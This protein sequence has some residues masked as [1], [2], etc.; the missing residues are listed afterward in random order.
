MAEVP[1][2]K[3][4]DEAHG[5]SDAHHDGH[6]VRGMGLVLGVGA[7]GDRR[8]QDFGKGVLTGRGAADGPEDAHPACDSERGLSTGRCL[9]LLRHRDGTS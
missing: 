1:V 3:A 7:D 4:V 8:Q 5:A 9:V 6:H 2:G